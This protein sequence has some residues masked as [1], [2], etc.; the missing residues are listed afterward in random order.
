MLPTAQF[1]GKPCSWSRKWKWLEQSALPVHHHKTLFQTSF[2]ACQNHEITDSPP[3][4]PR[5]AAIIRAANT[6]QKM[7]CKTNYS[8]QKTRASNRDNAINILYS[9]LQVYLMHIFYAGCFML[10]P[11]WMQQKMHHCIPIVLIYLNVLNSCHSGRSGLQHLSPKRSQLP[12]LR[13]VPGGEK[14]IQA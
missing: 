12:Q 2:S 7:A 3:L 11:S 4:V 10:G 14:Y 1:V 9:Q 6:L 8:N 13:Y 5:K